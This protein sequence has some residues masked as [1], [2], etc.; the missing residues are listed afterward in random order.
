MLLALLISLFPPFEFGENNTKT[1]PDKGGN[2]D[3]SEI[4]DKLPIKKYDFIFNNNK[5]SIV[6]DSNTFTPKFYS[7]DSIELKRKEWSNKRIEF[8][9][10]F[11]EPIYSDKTVL[12]K[13]THPYKE[14]WIYINGKRTKIFQ[15]NGINYP[16]DFDPHF[17]DQWAINYNEVKKEYDK[18][19]NNWDTKDVNTFD[20]VRKYYKYNVTEPVYYLLDR[21]LILSELFVEYI[22][23]ILLSII[24]GYLIQRFIPEKLMKI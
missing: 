19:P 24:S 16:I 3:I 4:A 1:I 12:F 10:E 18:S 5:K 13:T 9:G 6:L 17:T 21:K 23:A 2:S 8:E 15:K 20:S 22:I 11:N 14:K 7:K